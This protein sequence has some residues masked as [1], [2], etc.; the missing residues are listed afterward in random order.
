[1]KH[2]L[3]ILTFALFAC[4][5]TRSVTKTTTVKTS[6]SSAIKFSDAD[7]DCQRFRQVSNRKK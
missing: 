1:M 2:V 3:L 6:K 7:F 5:V 4:I